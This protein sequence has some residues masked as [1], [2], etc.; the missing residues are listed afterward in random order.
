M[1]PTI[2]CPAGSFVVENE[3]GP[4]VACGIEG[5][6]LAVMDNPRSVQGFCSLHYTQCPAWIAD[7]ERDPAVLAAQGRPRLTRCSVCDGTGILKVVQE[8]N[9]IMFP[10]EIPCDECAGTGKVVWHKSDDEDS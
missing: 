2:R 7:K 4:G 1:A 9:G 3:K 5:R 6:F 8:R 10:D